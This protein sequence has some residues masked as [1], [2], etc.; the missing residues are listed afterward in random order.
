MP[1]NLY[2]LLKSLVLLER[3]HRSTPKVSAPTSR[4]IQQKLRLRQTGKIA[5]SRKPL[6]HLISRLSSVSSKFRKDSLS[7][8]TDKNHLKVAR[9]PLKANPAGGTVIIAWRKR[10]DRKN[11]HMKA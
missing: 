6:G 8:Q 2:S 10:S 9:P 11:R 3:L 5:R 4:H 1:L 7:D